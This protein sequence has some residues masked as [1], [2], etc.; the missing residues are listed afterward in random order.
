M[1]RLISHGKESH[2]KETI[3]LAVEIV[4]FTNPLRK[5]GIDFFTFAKLRQAELQPKMTHINVNFVKLI[6][7]YIENISVG[8][9]R[10][11]S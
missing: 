5:D 8:Q 1:E 11:V 10:F 6:F 9:L 7:L 4:K 3:I 2:I